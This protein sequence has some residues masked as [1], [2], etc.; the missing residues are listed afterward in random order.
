MRVLHV[1]YELKPSG[2]EAM[3]RAAARHWAAQGVQCDILGT[4]ATPGPYAPVLEAAGYRV[5][6]LPFRRSP[7]FFLNLLRWLRRERY[8]VVH[9][10]MEA[11]N[12]W[13]GLIAR[14]AGATGVVRTVHSTFNFEGGLRG[15][16]ALQRRLLW[17]LGV[18][19]V[20]ISPSVV[21]T[22]RLCFGNQT[23]LVFNWY[24]EPRFR[25]ATPSE[26]LAARRRL[27]LTD[28]TFA[29]VSVGN[30]SSIKNHST[31]LRAMVE[32][33]SEA[34]WVYL[35][36][37][38]EAPE[39]DERALAEHLGLSSRVRFLGAIEDILPVLHAAD[40]FVMPSTHEGFGV[41]AVEALAAGLPALLTDVPGLRDLQT[42]FPG[43]T[44][45]PP[46]SAALAAALAQLAALPDAARLAIAADYPALARRCFGIEQGVRGY[47]EI[48]RS[49]AR[50]AVDRGPS[51]PLT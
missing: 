3:L 40:A 39:Q 18:V 11:A 22:E 27:G 10:H 12:F 2:A 20:A 37:G 24:D 16:R 32:D 33:T 38:A 23:R 50:C 21:A 31:L 46:T 13:F 28:G 8:D 4:G 14:L 30:C 15:R 47:S 34:S 44:Y 29:F 5:H 43:V 19:H 26:R 9:L 7:L 42:C 35:H 49:A 1:L 41:A 48:Y 36:V 51:C 17:A 45:A 25:P 6:H